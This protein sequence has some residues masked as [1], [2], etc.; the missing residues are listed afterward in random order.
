MWNLANIFSILIPTFS[1][2]TY[3]SLF[4][5]TTKTTTDGLKYQI[6]HCYCPP[7]SVDLNWVNC[8]GNLEKI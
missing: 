2:S 3:L 1:L 8:E 7:V 6:E 5:Q 4:L